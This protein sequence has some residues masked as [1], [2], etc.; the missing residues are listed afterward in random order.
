MILCIFHDSY[1]SFLKRLNA[2]HH[3]VRFMIKEI[4]LKRR[5]YIRTEMAKLDFRSIDNKDM[6][7]SVCIKRDYKYQYKHINKKY[8]TDTFMRSHQ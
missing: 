1:L 8:L 5:G 2:V 6:D 7:V 3:P 4:A